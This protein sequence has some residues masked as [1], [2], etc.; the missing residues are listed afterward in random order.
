MECLENRKFYF[1]TINVPS[2]TL[3]KPCFVNSKLERERRGQGVMFSNNSEEIILFIKNKNH[4]D[5]STDFTYPGRLT[6][7]DSLFELLAP[8]RLV[9]HFL[10]VSAS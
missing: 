10:A 4:T 2:L 7:Q 3:K 5:H 1:Q 6:S 8:G 9:P